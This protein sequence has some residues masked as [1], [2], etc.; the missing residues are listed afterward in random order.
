M[1]TILY[2]KLGPNADPI[3][4]QGLNDFLTDLSSVAQAVQTRLALWQGEW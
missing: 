2:R 1:T 4:G 3:R